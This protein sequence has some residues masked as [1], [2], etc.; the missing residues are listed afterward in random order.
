LALEESRREI[1]RTTS[2]DSA[3]HIVAGS[4]LSQSAI[5]D[6]LSLGVG[7]PV[8]ESATPA[9]ANPWGGPV[10][11]PWSP[12]P[13]STSLSANS[14]LYPTLG[15]TTSTLDPWAPAPSATAPP[16]SDAAPFLNSIAP[17]P[18]T[19]SSADPWES[20]TGSS[21]TSAVLVPTPVSMSNSEALKQRKT[22][23]SF[24]GENSALVNLDNLMGTTSI[25][26]KPG[27]STTTTTNSTNPFA[28]TQRPSPTL[29]EMRA[30]RGPDGLPLPLQPQPA[31]NGSAS[32]TNPFISF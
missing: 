3:P 30:H 10:A 12:A 18:A 32:T 15:T 22:P 16:A 1:N 11:D 19:D 24:L 27:T 20:L 8:T 13:P 17:V 7:I 29:N 23:E 14:Q 9:N 2:L 31:N 21:S 5:D 25:Q 4:T 28:S 26:P 6:L